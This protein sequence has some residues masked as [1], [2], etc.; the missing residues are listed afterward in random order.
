MFF[1]SPPVDRHA[2]SGPLD[3]KLLHLGSERARVQ[4]KQVRGSAGA[5]DSPSRVL[6]HVTDVITLGLDEWPYALDEAGAVA[7]RIGGHTGE[8]AHIQDTVA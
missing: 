2:R 8:V 6:E 5:L 3:A 1:S 4:P 7:G